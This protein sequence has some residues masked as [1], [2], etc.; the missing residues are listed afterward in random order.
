MEW[1]AGFAWVSKEFALSKELTLISI[2]LFADQLPTWALVV[3]MIAAGCVVIL[4]GSRFTRRA[5]ELAERL[6]LGGGWVGMILL[7]TATS[8]PELVSAG[9]AIRLGNV[10]LALGGI[11]GSCC[12]NITII[13]ILNA[14][15][16][17]GSILRSVSSSHTLTSS[18]GLILMILALLWLVMAN[19]FATSELAAQVSEATWAVM[20][21]VGYIGCMRLVYRFENA[22][23]TV[24]ILPVESQLKEK[25]P[26][27][28]L[29]ALGLVLVASAWWLAKIG[30]VLSAH[31]I[32]MI[33]RS[34]GATFVGA[35]FLAFSTSLPEIVT[36]LS[37]IKLGKLDM[38]LGNIFGSNM[39]NIFALP[40]LKVISLCSG[41][42]ILFRDGQFDM[43]QNLFTGLL[44]ILL[45]GIAVG[46][47]AYK[48]KRKLL[49]RFGFDSVLIGVVY[50]GGMALLLMGG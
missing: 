6:N 29:A 33:G 43:T 16:G 42:S 37:A 5:D 3:E 18:F 26:Y 36:S 32:K 25:P 8:L 50:V 23:N 15:L 10:D 17:G 4:A 12:F 40:I 1:L 22:G 47:L 39:F 35:V 41:E 19:K 14:A 30:D 49:R 9:T 21:F 28:S 7:A 48:S 11:L 13:V 27:V 20:I 24:P 44:A 34:L 31:E 2:W 45:T 46:G 38:A